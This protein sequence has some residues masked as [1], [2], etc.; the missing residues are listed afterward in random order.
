MDG[1]QKEKQNTYHES[2]KKGKHEII[3]F[4]NFNLLNFRVF[5]ISPAAPSCHAEVVTKAE[6]SATAG[7]FVCPVECICILYST[8]VIICF[9][10][11]HL[12]FDIHLAFGL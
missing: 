9:E 4:L 5:K 11:W 3:I 12:S 6:A 2:T 10:F 1:E 8:G 7:V